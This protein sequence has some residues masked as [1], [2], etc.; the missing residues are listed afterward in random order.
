MS[1]LSTYGPPAAAA[2]TSLFVMSTAAAAAAT[3]SLPSVIAMNQ[4]LKG[5]EVSITYANLPKDGYLV[6]IQA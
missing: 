6:F 1:R 5:G 4:K 3:S 2:L